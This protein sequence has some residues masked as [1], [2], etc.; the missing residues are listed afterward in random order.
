MP[1]LPNTGYEPDYS[2]NSG[3]YFWNHSHS[4]WNICILTYI[5]LSGRRISPHL[6]HCRIAYSQSLLCFLSDEENMCSYHP[7]L[8]GNVLEPVTRTIFF[9]D[10]YSDRDFVCDNHSHT[11]DCSYRIAVSVC[12]I[13]DMY[14]YCCNKQL[15]CSLPWMW[16][17][18]LSFQKRST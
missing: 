15:S 13:L 17:P 6:F 3:S 4:G 10:H 1:V 16:Q 18:V 14:R 8:S 9:Q 5:L 7:R 12:Y 2:R 11:P